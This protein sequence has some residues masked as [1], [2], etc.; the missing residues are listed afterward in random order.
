MNFIARFMDGLRA[1]I[2]E[3]FSVIFYSVLIAYPVSITLGNNPDLAY[4]MFFFVPLFLIFS[5]YI[6]RVQKRSILELV[7]KIPGYLFIAL[8]SF[9]ISF[10]K[11][12]EQD[13]SSGGI[14]ILCIFGI[15][16]FIFR[17][18][19]RY[20]KPVVFKPFN[21]RQYPISMWISLITC[22]FSTS[23][24][25]E[26]FLSAGENHWGLGEF[27]GTMFAILLFGLVALISGSYFL[28]S[29]LAGRR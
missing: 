5:P 13:S 10:S 19:K 20:N 23:V 1:S 25:A 6:K 9:G 24:V 12:I 21:E 27:F 7:V 3:I 11:F 15:I 29:I 2:G 22:I 26:G 18:L 14:A 16:W 28:I 8:V 4:I 17:T